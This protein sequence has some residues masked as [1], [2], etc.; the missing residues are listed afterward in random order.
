VTTFTVVV[1]A[2]VYLAMALGSVPGF[3]V[4]RA[5]AA[6]I[7]ALVLQVA[8]SIEEKSAWA[9]VDYQTMALMFGLM[10]VSA[11]FTMSGFYTAVTARLAA[12]RATP[13]ALLG[14]IV[15]AV[16]ALSAFLTNN[17]VAVAMAPLL[18]N[19]CGARKLNPVPFLL[20]LGFAANAGSVATIIGSPQ[21]MIVAQQLDLPFVEY[22]LATIVPVLFALLVIWGVLFVRY[23][24]HWMR[25]TVAGSIGGGVPYNRNEAIKGVIVAL[26]VLF[27][28]IFTDIDR[29][30]VALAAAGIL[31]LNRSFASR[32][33]LR[34]VDGGLLIMLFGLFIVNAA[35]AAT[36]LPDQVI[37]HLQHRGVDLTDSG[38]LFAITAL[39]SDIVGNTPA[40]ILLGPY[41]EGINDGIAVTL[42]SGFSSNLIVFGSLATIIV[43]EAAKDRGIVIS[44]AEF[45]RVGVPIALITLAFAFGWV[46]LRVA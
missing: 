14:V 39:L 36:G 7:G 12:M 33:M 19:A 15:V 21:N 38:W 10:V 13:E 9:A 5:G 27:A 24:G 8:D 43:V 37:Q 28:F 34:E 4:D 30:H 44:F 1:F 3:K 35:F 25:E 29:V 16:G 45:S 17:V 20:A 41:L 40:V 6:L 23:R 32:D 11:Q 26:A 2:L 46:V 18:V 42:A 31:L 22:T